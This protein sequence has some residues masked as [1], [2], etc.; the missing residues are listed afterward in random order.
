M[1]KYKRPSVR[2]AVTRW[3]WTRKL[4]LLALLISMACYS[5]LDRAVMP[6]D[7]A[8][9]QAQTK[10]AHDVAAT[11][12]PITV[13]A[14][15]GSGVILQGRGILRAGD[16]LDGWSVESVAGGVATLRRGADAAL[17]RSGSVFDAASGAVSR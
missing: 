12:E 10:G 11:S 1:K 8:H 6:E 3:V 4:P 17:L 14:V 15:G 9:L 7:I 16:T 2:R 5:R 13:R